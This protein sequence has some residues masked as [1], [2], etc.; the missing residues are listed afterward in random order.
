MARFQVV[1]DLGNGAIAIDLGGRTV[2]LRVQGK[3]EYYCE[4]ESV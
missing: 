4:K 2:E 3:T 1:L